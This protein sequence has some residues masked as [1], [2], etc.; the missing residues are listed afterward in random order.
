MNICITS[1]GT[2]AESQDS[3]KDELS[4]FESQVE[5]CTVRLAQIDKHRK[6]VLANALLGLKS[7]LS[8]L[9]WVLKYKKSDR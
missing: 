4:N 3:S 2:K 6:P 7:R 8:D 9:Q 1:F 5:R